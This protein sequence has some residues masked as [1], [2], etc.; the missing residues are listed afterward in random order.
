LRQPVYGL[1][2][3]LVTSTTPLGTTLADLGFRLSSADHALF[4]CS[5]PHP[6]F[7]LVYINNLVATLGRALMASL[8]L[9]KRHACTSLGELCIYLGSHITRDRAA[10]TITL[11]ESRMVHQVLQRFELQISTILPTPL[12]I[13]HGLNAPVCDKPVEPSGCYAEL[14]GCLMYLMTFTRPDLANPLC[15]LACFVARVKHRFVKWTAARKV[16]K[17]LATTSGMVLMLGGKQPLR[18]TRH[19]DSAWAD[20]EETNRST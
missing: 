8:I 14:V 19:C 16:A 12:A 1:R 18:F 4:V 15:V 20:D 13:D 10:C 9:L 3:V 7:A 6:F 5:G 2:R 17:Y 11:S